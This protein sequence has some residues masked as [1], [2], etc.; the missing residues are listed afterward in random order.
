MNAKRLPLTLTLL[1]LLLLTCS[2]IASNTVFPNHQYR[3]QNYYP[4]SSGSYRAANYSV[5]SYDHSP[6]SSSSYEYSSRRVETS[7]NHMPRHAFNWHYN[8]P[9]VT[10][11]PRRF[12]MGPIIVF[13]NSE[14]VRKIDPSNTVTLLITN[15]NGSQTPIQLIKTSDASGYKG[16]KGEY[17]SEM[18]TKGQLKAMYG[19]WTI[20]NNVQQMTETA[21]KHTVWI[22]NYNGS[23]TPVEFKIVGRS[24]IGP[25]GE[26]YPAKPTEAQLRPVYG[27]DSN[28]AV[29]NSV[30]ALIDNGDG[31]HTTVVLMKKDSAYVGPRGEHYQTMPT[32][33]QLKMAYCKK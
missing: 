20:V 14:A 32:E 16:P 23:R 9:M 31:T 24:Y 6:F 27:L 13:D 3:S 15:D 30:T 12:P 2:A 10:S 19:K 17:Y 28:S 25:K 33:Q 4:A 21:S 11:K 26:H 29:G 1:S 18:P 22:T 5:A 8:W 7:F